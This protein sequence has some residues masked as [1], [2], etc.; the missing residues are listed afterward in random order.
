[1]CTDCSGIY[2]FHTVDNIDL[3]SLFGDSICPP[4][5]GCNSYGNDLEAC[6][7]DNFCAFLASNAVGE[8]CIGFY[9]FFFFFAVINFCLNY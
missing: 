9:Y 3:F 7:S 4:F 1:M 8:N 2:C 5:G 6:V